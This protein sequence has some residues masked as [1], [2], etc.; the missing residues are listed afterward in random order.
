MSAF[1]RKTIF[2]L[3]EKVEHLVAGDGTWLRARYPR[4]EIGRWT[5]GWLRVIDAGEG[6]TLKIG[7]FCSI[8][9]G[10][11]VLLGGEHHTEWITTFPF[12]AL[13]RAAR[14]IPGHPKTKGDVIIGNDVWIGQDALILSGVTIGDGAVIAA[15]AVITKNVEPYTIVGGNPARIIRKRF[16][17]DVIAQLIKIKWWEWSD[18]EIERNLPLLL[19]PDVD[20]LIRYAETGSR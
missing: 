9:K 10:V 14:A 4:Y 11:T 7:A 2:A 15:R 5:Y 12:P 20:A 19:S 18:A 17:D 3:L 6:A 8:A 16:A 13:W 1:I